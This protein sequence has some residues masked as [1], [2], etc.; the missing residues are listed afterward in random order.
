MYLLIVAV[1]KA[2]FT[3][4]EIDHMKRFYCIGCLLVLVCLS[5]VSQ[6]TTKE[7][8]DGSA[9]KDVTSDES[10]PPAKTAPGPRLIGSGDVITF[11]SGAIL[12]GVQVLRS[13]PLEYVIEVI[14]GVDPLVIAAKHIQ[15]VKYDSIDP[16]RERRHAA[17]LGQ[18]DQQTMIRGQEMSPELINKLT[19]P[20]EPT[21]E[22]VFKNEDFIK[23]LSILSKKMEVKIEFAPEIKDIPVETR[24]WDLEIKK[25]ATV[26]SI[27][28][29]DFAKKFKN[30]HVEYLFDIIFVGLKKETATPPVNSNIP[31][32]TTEQSNRQ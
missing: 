6:S 18:I 12:D 8:N 13:S 19:I 7:T 24:K 32:R 3:N 2:E 29:K 22:L 25:G 30:I 9:S 26:G 14:E 31:I 10:A 1:V 5:A 21:P 17:A 4:M 15:S 11:K 27:L 20:I 16:L 28:Q 23:V